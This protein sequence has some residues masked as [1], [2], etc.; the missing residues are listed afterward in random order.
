MKE[1]MTTT[2]HKLSRPITDS[3]LIQALKNSMGPIFAHF[4]EKLGDWSEGKV[5][6]IRIIATAG[7]L[8]LEYGIGDAANASDQRPPT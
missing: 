3:E 4:E 1:G 6:D 2:H 5:L 7:K 8:K